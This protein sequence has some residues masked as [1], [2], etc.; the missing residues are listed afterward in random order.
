MHSAAV[1]DEPSGGLERAPYEVLARVAVHPTSPTPLDATFP[2]GRCAGRGRRGVRRR[3]RRGGHRRAQARRGCSVA[4]PNVGG[5]VSPSHRFRRFVGR[6]ARQARLGCLRVNNSAD[7]GVD[8]PLGPDFDV[9]QARGKL[10]GRPADTGHGAPHGHPTTHRAQRSAASNN[11]AAVRPD[12]RGASR[13]AM[14]GRIGSFPGTVSVPSIPAPERTRASPS[15][16]GG[17][18][19]VPGQCPRERQ[20]ESR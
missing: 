17:R 18:D 7:T 4:G 5:P 19:P 6:W 14:D 9:S 10:A 3:A 15:R 13:I 12:R 1:T 2:A 11:A 20:A 16:P 8:W